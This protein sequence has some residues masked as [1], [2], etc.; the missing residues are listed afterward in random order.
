MRL[1]SALCDDESFERFDA[2]AMTGVLLPELL[3]L[4]FNETFIRC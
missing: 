1:T 2:D 3:G 4:S